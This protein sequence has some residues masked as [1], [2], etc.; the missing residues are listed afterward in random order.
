MAGLWETDSI[1][2][3]PLANSQYPAYSSNWQF[4]FPHTSVSGDG[5][6]HSDMAVDSSGT[7]KAG[8]NSG[9]SPIV[10]EVINAT[11]AQLT[12]LNTRSGRQQ[13][14]RGI[15]RFYT[16]HA[17]ERHFELH[18]VTELLAY[19]GSSFVPDLDYHSNIYADP[20]GTTHSDSTLLGLFNGAQ[21]VTATIGSDNN[22]VAFTFA[23]PSVNYAQFNGVALSAVQNDGVSQYFLFQPSISPTTTVRCRLVANTAAATAAAGL[24]A[25]Q[26]LT[27][28]VLTRTDMGAVASQI[29]PLTAGQS[30]TFPRPIEL[31]VLGVLNVGPGGTPTPTPSPTASPTATPSPSPTATP[32]P[33]PGAGQVFTSASSI[34]LSGSNGGRSLPYPAAINVSAVVGK[35]T[36]VSARLNNASQPSS[37]WALDLRI[38]LVGPT[39]Q[40]VALMSNAGGS[41]SLGGVTVTF[42]DAAAS[43]LPKTSAIATGSYRP[44]N[45]TS[46]SLNMPSPAPSA[47]PGSTLALFNGSNP[48]R[49]LESLHLRQLQLRQRL[50]RGR[51]E[52]HLRDA[53]G[54]AR[55]A[56]ES[57]DHGPQQQRDLEWNGQSLRTADNLAFPV[58]PG[59]QLRERSAMAKCRQRHRGGQCQR[60]ADRIATGDDLSLPP[61]GDECHRHD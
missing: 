7:G 28:N 42:D 47:T 32:T 14:F 31:I 33:T 26:S 27:V 39:G 34:G 57:R 10:T 3:T 43:A 6:I 60:A 29:S 17:S 13:I 1:A 21:K 53:S 59:R 8:N 51:L 52:P 2:L 12:A 40:S 36:K 58:W 37:S 49:H 16:E 41:Y 61:G 5:D 46:G 48:K 20:N 9:A 25:N 50:G 35:I 4:I 24:S 18:P 19:N 56:L 22:Q 23:S 30:K 15:F 11:S 45:Y 38:V 44:A 55:R 54:R